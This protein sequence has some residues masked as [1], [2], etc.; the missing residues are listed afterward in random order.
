MI[1]DNNCIFDH[2]AAITTT[3]D[4]E[5]VI[6]LTLAEDIGD[7]GGMADLNVICTLAAP[8]DSSANTLT[9]STSYTIFE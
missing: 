1:L 9:D 4:S 3:R 5:N 6:D 7:G 2:A 8:F